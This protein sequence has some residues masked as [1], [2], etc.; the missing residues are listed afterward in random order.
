[1]GPDSKV[2]LTKGRKAAEKYK[3]TYG[4]KRWIRERGGMVFLLWV[5]TS[6]FPLEKIPVSQLVRELASVMQ[7][8]TQQP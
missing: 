7:E 3:L 1:M 6:F 5:L 8:Y 4:G 2:L